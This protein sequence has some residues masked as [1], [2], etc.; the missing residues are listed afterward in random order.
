MKSA[1][2]VFMRGLLWRD[3]R[4][5]MK[6]SHTQK[7]K[8]SLPRCSV[9]THCLRPLRYLLEPVLD[10]ELQDAGIAAE[11]LNP[12][13]V[14]RTQARRRVAPV[15]GVEEIERL[16]ARLHLVAGRPGKVSRHG[17][18]RLPGPRALDAVALVVAKRAGRRVREGCAVQVVEQRLVSIDLVGHLI[19]PVGQAVEPRHARGYGEPGARPRGRSEEHTSELQSQSNLVCRLLLEK[20]KKK[21]KRHRE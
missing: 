3:K 13:E 1:T 11:G 21:D 16:D 19:D 10:P 8:T 17:Q 18:V 6:R 9:C 12:A 7:R 20:K 5:R 15:E 4:D 14:A 2:R